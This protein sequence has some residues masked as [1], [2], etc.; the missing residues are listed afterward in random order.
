MINA[1]RMS[2]RPLLSMPSM[3]MV[4]GQRSRVGTCYAIAY[5]GEGEGKERPHT[6]VSTSPSVR[7]I[8]FQSRR[9]EKSLYG[10][11]RDSM[12]WKKQRAPFLAPWTVFRC[13]PEKSPIRVNGS[14]NCRPQLPQSYQA[15]I[16][17][18]IAWTPSGRS[19]E[20]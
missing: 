15:N 17:S 20:L 8:C 1:I 11:M 2:A 14:V 9:Q 19:Y 5:A 7:V 13:S 16:D 10:S 18:W 12:R 6:S 4:R 3:K